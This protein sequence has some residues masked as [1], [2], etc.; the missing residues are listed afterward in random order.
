MP[1]RPSELQYVE[2]PLLEQLKS[3]GWSVK[4]LNDAEKHLPE[5]SFRSSLREVIIPSKFKDALRRLNSWLEDDQV[6]ALCEQMQTY[7][8]P[9]EK[10]LDNNIVVFDRLMD[11]LSAYNE[12]TGDEETVKL[13]D[14]DDMEHFDPATSK[15]EY[16]AISQYKVRIP[17]TH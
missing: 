11:G 6:D 9:T 17:G 4:V 12:E 14:W 15:N 3:L 13:I 2:T 10:L 7:D 1:G 16:L 8:Y 5:S